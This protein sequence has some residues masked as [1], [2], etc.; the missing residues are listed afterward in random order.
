MKAVGIIRN[1][2]TLGR[3][4][5]PMELRRTM[6]IATGDPIEIFTDNEGHIILRKYQINGSLEESI[7]DLKNAVSVYGNGL[8][9]D[10]ASA[11]RQHCEAMQKLIAQEADKT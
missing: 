10:V 4:V 1:L 6:N 3:I 2:D 9:S 8:P 11:I 5:I 7:S